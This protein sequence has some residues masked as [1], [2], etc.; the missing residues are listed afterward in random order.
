[1]KIASCR[2][3]QPYGRNSEYK[4]PKQNEVDKNAKAFLR[5]RG[6][7]VLLHRVWSGIAKQMM[8]GKK[9]RDVFLLTYTT[10]RLASHACH[11]LIV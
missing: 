9:R 11:V 1:M 7:C 5:P 10:S 2:Y 4:E 8:N 6:F 3:S